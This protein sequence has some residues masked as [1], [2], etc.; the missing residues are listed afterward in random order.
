MAGMNASYH[1]LVGPM[2]WDIVGMN[3]YHV[4][5][6]KFLFVA[7]TKDGICIKEEGPIEDEKYIWNRL[8]NRADQHA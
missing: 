6:K 7:M 4:A 2:G 3:H 5:G 1:N 8:W